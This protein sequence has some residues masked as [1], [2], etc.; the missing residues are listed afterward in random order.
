MIRRT[1]GL[2]LA[3]LALAA[4]AGAQNPPPAPPTRPP[5]GADTAR[6]PTAAAAAD[7]A[8][9]RVR[10]DTG[11]AARHD[12][13]QVPDSLSPDS[14]AAQLPRL[15]APQGPLPAAS[16]IVFDHDALWFSGALTLGELLDRVPGVF[17]ARA[18]WFA[19]PEVLHYAGQG[20]AS[21]QVFWD[22]FAL[23]P[24]GRD[25]A[26]VDIGQIS[27]GLLQR[28]EVEVLPSELRIYLFSDGQPVRRPRTETSFATGDASTNTYRIRYLNRWKGGAGIGVGVEYLGT[29]AGRLNS[30]RANDLNVWAKASWAP[31]TRFGVEYQYLSTSVNRDR[32]SVLGAAGD[33]IGIGNPE[34]HRSDLFFRGYAAT[35]DDGMGL[36]FDALVGSTSYTDSLPALNTSELQGAAIV[37]YRAHRWSG[38]VTT[39]VREGA[40]PVQLQLRAAVSPLSLLTVS[41]TAIVSSHTGGRHSLDLSA[42]AELRPWRALALHAA[43]RMRDAVAQPNVLTDTAQKVTDVSGGL[44]FTSRALDLDVTAAQHG[45]FE[46]PLYGVFDTIVPAYPSVAVRTVTASLALRPALWFTV[47]GWYRHPLDAVTSAYEPPHHARWTATFRSRLLPV[48]RRNA[49]DFIAEFGV[50]SWS[51]GAVGVDA[52]GNPVHLPGAVVMDWRAELRLLGAA[53]FWTLRNAGNEHYIVIP[54]VKM[55]TPGQRY[56]V[57]WEFTN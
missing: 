47:A 38:E 41:G 15:G 13:A 54:G 7:T 26:G 45:R 29:A 24:L 19:R 11:L 37:G 46:A 27:L 8:T 57:R 48:L 10:A 16:R 36:R 43:A 42:G 31:S 22:G 39:R 35:R 20:A 44:A 28:V 25:S 21:V 3:A 53:L 40:T 52:L 9:R 50:E 30:G 4:A 1:G 2:L 56:G 5:A 34:S 17:L 32:F 18:G 55:Q 23:D 12:T 49:F 33:S 51:H 14:F 6:A